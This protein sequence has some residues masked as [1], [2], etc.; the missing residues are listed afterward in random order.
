[1]SSDFPT[2]TIG[3]VGLGLIGGSFA[4]AYKKY[5][6][7]RV[8]GYNRTQST[9]QQALE[10]GTLDGLLTEENISECDLLLLALYPG[11]IISFLKEHAPRIKKTAIVMDGGG[12]KRDIC[13]DCQPIAHEYGFTFVGGHPMA[14]KKYSGYEYCTADLFHNA[15]MVVVPENLEDTAL[16]DRVKE[17]LAP[18]DFGQI[19]VCD[20]EKHD[21]MIAFTSQMAHLVSNAYIKSPT[22]R[23]H[24]GFSAGSYKD[25]TRVAWLNET[26]WTELFLENRDN[27]IQ[28]LDYIMGFLAEYREALA[29]QNADR[30][31]QLLHEGKVCKE[32]VD[33]I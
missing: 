31:W 2:K 12:T 23:E 26:M 13:R 27:L 30:L 20:A 24:K 33:G 8:L 5:S 18:C 1:M 28:E 10:D 25:M 9:A 3:I 17:L 32:E 6:D 14:G 16:I 19:T 21:K 11:A 22:A 15:S 29:E 4:K 7:Y